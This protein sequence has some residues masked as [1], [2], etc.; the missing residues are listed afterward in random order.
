MQLKG[1][2]YKAEK[3]FEVFDMSHSAGFRML[4]ESLR[5]FYHQDYNEIWDC[6][7]KITG[8]Q[9]QKA[10]S[11]LKEKELSVDEKTLTWA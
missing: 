2:L 6:K 9:I 11:I 7:L 4:N 10:D 8:A 3:V 1:I 5:Q